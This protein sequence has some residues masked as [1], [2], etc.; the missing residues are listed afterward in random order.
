ELDKVY[1]ENTTFE[2][3]GET[4]Q[5]FQDTLRRTSD[6]FIATAT[7]TIVGKSRAKIK[8][9]KLDVIAAL[10]LIQDLSRGEHFKFDNEFDEQL[11]S[12]ILAD[13]EIPVAGRVTS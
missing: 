10:L 3:N 7:K 13:K 12:H 5:R 8:F 9:R 1:H 4:A 6:V 11:A 2:V